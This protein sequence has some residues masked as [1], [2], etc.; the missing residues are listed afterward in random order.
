VLGDDTRSFL[1]IVRSLGR[2]GIA[3]HAAPAD[4]R[5]PAL[6]S[7][8]IAAMHRL[9]PYLGDGATWCAVVG[10]LLR[11]ESFDLVIPCDERTL[12]PFDRHRASF[13]G[14]ARLALPGPEA[15]EILFDKQRTRQLAAAQAVPLAPGRLVR[16]S[17][18]A[19]TLIAELGLPLVLKPCRSYRLEALHARG[20]AEIFAS[21]TTLA[22][23]L[24][25]LG[26]A[27]HLAESYFAGR[28][29]GISV[30]ASRGTIL[31][32]FQHTR[33]RERGGAGFYR[34]ST[35]LAPDLLAAVERMF[36]AIAFTGVAM[37]EFKIDPRTGTWILLEVNARPWGSMPLPLALN[38]DFPSLWYRL[39]VEGDEA[40]PRSY[41]SGIYAR[42]LLPDARQILAEAGDLRRR[43][44]A[45]I[46]HLLAAG[47]TFRRL[48]IG[49]EHL[50]VLVAD[51]PSPGL[52]EIGQAG[53]ELAAR[54]LQLLP[55]SQPALRRRDRRLVRR[56]MG[57]ARGGPAT[58]A[59]LCRGN[60]CRSPFAAALLRRH[61][62]NRV[63]DLSVLSAGT[64][65][66]EGAPS[67]PAAVAAAGALGIDLAAHRSACLA[68]RDAAEATL[69][70]VFDERNRFDLGARH[71]A[72]LARTVM[73]G[74]FLDAKDGPR[75]IADPDGGDEATFART[76]A[77]I[78]LAVAAL[79][80]AV[81]E[82]LAA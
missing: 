43:P 10:E 79:A 24:A 82:S 69:A 45:M 59:M 77:R 8:Y 75:E 74:S 57:Q 73:L 49:R 32:A 50:D 68:E 63:P 33:A 40:P 64:L 65:P 11:R 47:A 18:S 67:P 48:A 14:L 80:A 25:R 44:A 62:G 58:V 51:D 55:G 52:A 15:I 66:R 76:Y 2:A 5:S 42:N 7:K 54:L 6:R 46:G 17:E 31:Q 23:A 20:R 16:P 78:A 3:V 27:Q 9:P 13:E 26:A 60:I 37:V 12:L 38:I 19:S 41:R 71:P 56:L 61:L 4:F 72:L 22:D 28:G 81:A 21:E 53:A 39:L 36:A 1:A 29:A 70:V 34:M 35:P 30:L